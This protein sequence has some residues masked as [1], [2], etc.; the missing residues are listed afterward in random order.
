M[1]DVKI[2]LQSSRRRPNSVKHARAHH[3]DSQD[4]AFRTQ[5]ASSPAHP[6]QP[7]TDK[8]IIMALNASASATRAL[9]SVL[10][11]PQAP[12]AVLASAR[13]QERREHC[14]MRRRQ[15]A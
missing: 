10:L 9:R 8:K 1:R 3:E 6:H 5:H 2:W 7:S 13:G 12:A 4:D 15:G 11:C 14:V